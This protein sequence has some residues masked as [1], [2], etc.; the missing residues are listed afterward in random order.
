M[1]ASLFCRNLFQ[2]ER[3]ESIGVP[4]GD[5][6]IGGQSPIRVQSMTTTNTNDTEASIAQ[7][8]R[9][10]EAG[11]QLVRL[12][13]QG[14]TE[15]ENLKNIVGG[16]RSRGYVSPIVADVHYSPGAAEVAALY[17]DKVRINP[18]NYMGGA[19][20][21]DSSAD[22]MTDA[23]WMNQIVEKLKP[24]VKICKKHETTIRIGV[25]H[26]SLS[27]RIMARYGDTAEGMV[28]SCIE[29][30]DALES[31]DFTDIVIS[32]KASNTRIMVETVRLLAATMRL[33]GRIYPLHLGVTEAG[34]DAEGRIKS[35]AGIGALLIDGLGDTIRV[36]LTEAPEAEIPVAQALCDYVMQKRERLN[37]PHPSV[38]SYSPYSYVRRQTTLVDGII[39][40]G[41]T[42][43]IVSDA[44]GRKKP[45]TT[46][47]DY[48][49]SNDKLGDAERYISDQSKFYADSDKCR[50]MLSPSMLD[51]YSGVAFVRVGFEDITPEFA[52]KL[53]QRTDVVLVFQ[54]Q[55]KNPT[56]EVRT[57]V[58]RMD[59][60]GVKAPVVPWLRYDTSDV[61]L[62][63]LQ[64]ATDTGLLFI[65]GLIDGLMLSNYSLDQDV[66][67]D[68][69]AEIMQAT[70]VRYSKAVFISCPGCGRTLYDIQSATQKIKARFS[71][72][73]G[74]K[75]GV[76]GCVINGI[77]EMADADYGYVG[78]THG[79]ISLYRGKTLIKKALP[80]DQAIDELK[81]LIEE[82]GLW[83]EREKE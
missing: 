25:N 82:D 60:L 27:D 68:T 72:L 21:F 75:I 56:V 4:V 52:E 48:V 59:E 50:A 16:L 8:I 32:I 6:V 37:L 18:G 47:S 35:A 3:T 49:F 17:A 69:V 41:K 9:I 14:R 46:G 33:R 83:R 2:Y 36:S 29:F 80:E 81:A 44:T 58:L 13:T 31:L 64:A 39:G 57:F 26:G 19:K 11:G 61:S 43:V 76:M 70:N 78:A 54:P 5:V 79:K 65:D 34:S 77:G 55:T 10:I 42:P 67:L 20:R 62:F 30:V 7:C 63:Q 28:A 74:L 45:L 66:I 51:G 24:L 53:R 12:T 22:N 71:H 15:A 73:T 23:E 40:G 1:D 38:G